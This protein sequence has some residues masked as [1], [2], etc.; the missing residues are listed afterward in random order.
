MTPFD[1][2]RRTLCL[3]LLALGLSQH[4]MAGQTEEVSALLA[5]K[6]G[7]ARAK[8]N[9]IADAVIKAASK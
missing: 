8:A 1:L 7:V 3:L 4:A 5:Q 6:F 2:M 9:T